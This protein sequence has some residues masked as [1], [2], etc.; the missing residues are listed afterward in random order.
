MDQPIVSGGWLDC[1]AARIIDALEKE[2]PIII[3]D[4]DTLRRKFRVEMFDFVL[5]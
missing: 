1:Q 3:Q 2:M 5:G 4:Q